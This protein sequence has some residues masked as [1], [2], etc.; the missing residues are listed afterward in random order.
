MKT[1]IARC[2]FSKYYFDTFQDCGHKDTQAVIE[3]Y[4]DQI[5]FIQ[6]PGSEMK[7]NQS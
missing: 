5:I 7:S 2:V 1:T 4:G 3:S 6:Q